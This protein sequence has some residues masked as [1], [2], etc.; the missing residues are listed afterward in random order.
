MVSSPKNLTLDSNVKF[1]ADD[2]MLFS[3]VNDPVIS[4]NDYNHDLNV[5]NH[6][7]YQWK[8]EFN[9]DPNK[10]ATEVLFSGKKNSP[11]QSSLFFLME[12]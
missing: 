3:I 6:W 8:M 11:C 2:T 10:K 7:A 4:A 12:L 5:I 1:Y 9:P